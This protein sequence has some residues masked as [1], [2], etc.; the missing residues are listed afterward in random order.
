LYLSC[1]GRT[2]HPLGTVVYSLSSSTAESQV[3]S[4]G[5][6]ACYC[7]DFRQME[8]IDAQVGLAKCLVDWLL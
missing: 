2:V 4:P 8:R 7:P 6:R 3:Q 1:D 5:R